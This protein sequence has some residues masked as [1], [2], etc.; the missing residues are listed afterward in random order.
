MGKPVSEKATFDLDGKTITV[1]IGWE[2]DE[3]RD[4]WELC[5]TVAVSD[6]EKALFSKW[7]RP[8]YYELR[9]L[10]SLWPED[11]YRQLQ[12]DG[13]LDWENALPPSN[14]GGWGYFYSNTRAVKCEQQ[15]DKNRLQEAVSA[16]GKSMGLCTPHTEALFRISKLIV[17]LQERRPT[18][19]ARAHYFG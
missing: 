15:T 5:G 18:E 2:A 6:A 8:D 11:I 4:S 14:R 3:K 17:E 1:D 12:Q 16:I 7:Y 19:S 10:E 9:H 13:F